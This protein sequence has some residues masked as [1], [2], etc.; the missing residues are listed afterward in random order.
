MV[1]RFLTHLVA[2]RGLAPSTVDSY[3]RDLADLERHLVAAGRPNVA[4]VAADDLVDWQRGALAKGL[5]A[6][7]R[8]RRLASVRG[9]LRYLRDEGER[10]DDPASSL[11]SPRRRRALPRVLSKDEV[12]ALLK[13]P[14][15][16]KPLGSRDRA[17]LEIMYASGLRVSEL[18]GLT[19]RQIDLRR[20][21]VRVLGKGRSERVVPLGSAALRTLESYLASDRGALGARGDVVFPGRAG[22]PL[23]RH[24]FWHRVRAM[25]R[26][27][28]IRADRVSPHVIRHSFATHLVENGADLR[29]VQALLGHSDISTTEIYTH[30][31]RERLRKL[32]DQFHP[33]A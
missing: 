22:G 6:A 26:T 2:V 24:A 18:V 1:E 11:A 4:A 19:T 33:R 28:G 17:M 15:P 16:T 29:T 3:R 5:S 8:R 20:G 32:Y 7:T 13:A 25:A 14:D 23:T 10:E 12:E 27:A 31:A 30:V 9:F 21:L